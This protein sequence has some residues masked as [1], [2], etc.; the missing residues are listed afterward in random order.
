M[1]LALSG[2]SVRPF[3]LSRIAVAG[4]VVT[5]LIVAACFG[6]GALLS[7]IGAVSDV[8][9]YRDHRTTPAYALLGWLASINVVLLLFNLV[10]A[11]PLDGGRLVQCI[12]W[13]R[14]FICQ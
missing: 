7:H 3:S 12:L 11:F 6:L 10:P 5:A 8:A 14:L 4:P 9:R 1:P 2:L 13:P